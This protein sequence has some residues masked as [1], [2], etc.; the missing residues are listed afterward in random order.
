MPTNPG[1]DN[2]AR[3]LAEPHASLRSALL[4]A[5]VSLAYV[6]GF[7]G[8]SLRSVSGRI[9]KS[10]TVIFQHFGGRQGLIDAAL[11]HERPQWVEGGGICDIPTVCTLRS[12][13]SS[14]QEPTFG[15]SL[16]DIGE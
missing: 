8:I 14:G 4:E 9:G 1:N 2:S 12:T 16:L 7:D 3:A 6:E 13:G 5:T 11:D 15:G 10:T